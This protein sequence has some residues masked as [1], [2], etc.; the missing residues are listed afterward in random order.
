MIGKEA[1]SLIGRETDSRPNSDWRAAIRDSRDWYGE[2]RRNAPWWMGWDMSDGLAAR[3]WRF[4]APGNPDGWTPVQQGAYGTLRND[5][6]LP[7]VMAWRDD[8]KEQMK[9]EI[10]ALELPT[11][12]SVSPGSTGIPARVLLD[13]GKRSGIT[14]APR[15]GQGAESIYTDGDLRELHRQAKWLAAKV[16]EFGDDVDDYR[17]RFA[18]SETD[19]WEV[20]FPMFEQLL[21]GVVLGWRVR[22]SNFNACAIELVAGRGGLSSERIRKRLRRPQSR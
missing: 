2:V 11:G 20:R 17:R 7:H 14:G 6:P 15:Q 9:R 5:L 12:D 18:L 22:A 3:L 21:C 4:V 16:Y 8:L 19:V 10:D 13:M 1:L